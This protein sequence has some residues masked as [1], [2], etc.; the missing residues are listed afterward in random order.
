MSGSAVEEARRACR[1]SLI[2]LLVAV[3]AVVSLVLTAT[4][5]HGMTASGATGSDQVDT[6][7]VPRPATVATFGWVCGG[8]AFVQLANTGDT[9]DLVSISGDEVTVMPGTILVHTLRSTSRPDQWIVGPLASITTQTQVPLTNATLD[10]TGAVRTN[11]CVS[12]WPTPAPTD[13]GEAATLAFT[14]DHTGDLISAGLLLCLV[15]TLALYANRR[16]RSR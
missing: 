8:P 1:S 16:L 3:I 10:G 9:P 14:G 11:G 12:L 13:V 2:G 5:A 6:P 7:A 15:G 4:A